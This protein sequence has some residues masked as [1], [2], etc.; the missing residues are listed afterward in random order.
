MENER[1][2][3]IDNEKHQTER[4][5]RAMKEKIREKKRNQRELDFFQNKIDS[6]KK[7]KEKE[8]KKFIVEHQ[9]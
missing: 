8:K 6:I 9:K 5:I 1:S 2:I 3:I 7:S 4:E